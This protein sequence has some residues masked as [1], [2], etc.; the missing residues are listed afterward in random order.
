MGQNQNPGGLP[1]QS[2]ESVC[3]QS[4]EYAD[5]A[6]ELQAFQEKLS[7]GI[8]AGTRAPHAKHFQAARSQYLAVL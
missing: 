6:E 2:S 1:L 8:M 4:D 7:E 5:R 3:C